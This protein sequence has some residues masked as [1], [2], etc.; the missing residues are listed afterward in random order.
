MN[1]NKDITKARLHYGIVGFLNAGSI[2][3]AS[4]FGLNWIYVAI[5]VV[6][7]QILGSIIKF[8]PVYTV[9]NE[10]IPDTTSMQKGK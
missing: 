9:L 3:L 10:L 5:A 4:E 1:T 7:I 6:I 8:C 2:L